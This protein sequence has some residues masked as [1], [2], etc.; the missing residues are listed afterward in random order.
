[1]RTHE[2]FVHAHAAP[3]DGGVALIIEFGRQAAVTLT[4]TPREAEHQVMVL[5]QALDLDEGNNSIEPL[6]VDADG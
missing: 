2:T 6:I 3:Q 5:N 4:L 1:M